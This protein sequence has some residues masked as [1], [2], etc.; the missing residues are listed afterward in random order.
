M[1][2]RLG[3]AVTRVPAYSPH[4]VAEFTIGLMLAVDRRIPRA[5]ARVRD[6][7]FALEGLLGHNL[8]GRTVG[9]VEYSE[10]GSG[11]KALGGGAPSG[12]VPLQVKL[13]ST[14]RLS[15][16]TDTGGGLVEGY[17]HDTAGVR[18]RNSSFLYNGTRTMYE[19]EG[20]TYDR[21]KGQG[22]CVMVREVAASTR[23]AETH[24]HARVCGRS[25]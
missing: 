15:L 9:V 24:S 17:P 10:N 3:I 2:P 20:F 19:R 7:N 1:Q 5:W 25:C 18:K 14:Y 23:V 6:N 16:K 8:H 21:P 12:N 13:G 11:P 22:N 4:A